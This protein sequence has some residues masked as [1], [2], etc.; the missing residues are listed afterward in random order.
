MRSTFG[1]QGEALSEPSAPSRWPSQNTWAKP[2]CSGHLDRTE[3]A[4]GSAVGRSEPKAP[5]GV[6]EPW[7]EP[8]TGCEAPCFKA[9]AVLNE[10]C[11]SGGFRAEPEHLA[12][13]GV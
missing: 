11:N 3:G 1:P 9:K 8:E 5:E 7:P 12:K 10:R 6:A 2:K 13:P 4:L